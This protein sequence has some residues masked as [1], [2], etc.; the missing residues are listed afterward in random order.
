MV[1]LSEAPL[2]EGT[3]RKVKS[4]VQMERSAALTE[5]D[6]HTRKLIFRFM[7]VLKW[8]HTTVM[9]NSCNMYLLTY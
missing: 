1:G 7:L 3:C 2:E 9:M 5:I 6:E 8:S 4:N